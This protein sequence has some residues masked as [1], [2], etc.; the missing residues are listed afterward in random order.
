MSPVRSGAAE[1]L[2]TAEELARLDRL[3][4]LTRRT[5]RGEN[6][7]ERRSRRIGAG[8]EF[9]DHRT[10]V[11][12]DDLRYVDWN[13]YFR[14]GDLVVKRFEAEENVRVF[15]AVDRSPSMEGRKALAA[16]RLA[17]AL[18]HV[19][20]RRRDAVTFAW[21]PATEEGPVITLRDPAR[22]PALLD[23]MARVP[24]AG[25]TRL[26][27]DLDRATAM[28]KRRGPA[29]LVSD[30]FDPAGA[31]AGLARLAARGFEVTALHVLDP[32]DAD[33]PVGEAVRCVDRETGE[34]VDVDV[35][36]AFAEAVHAAWRRRAERVRAW[37]APREIGWVA[38]DASK[39]VWD[40][41]REMLRDGVVVGG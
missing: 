39:P 19:A 1:P 33:L 36:E 4:L 10:Y 18:A 14:H 13:V 16:R 7:G 23:A 32:A 24:S 21:L 25:P 5:L 22:L 11:P 2:F 27:P 9:V 34:T 8:G 28:T 6:V 41:L 31:V 20:L 12:G 38:V 37:C 29:V 3:S 35:T 30:F 26:A 15:L 40:V 17:G